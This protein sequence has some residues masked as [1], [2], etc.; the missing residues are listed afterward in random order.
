M[1]TRSTRP[2]V[3]TSLRRWNDE[4]TQDDFNVEEECIERKT[5]TTITTIKRSYPS[6]NIRPSRSLKSLDAKEYPLALTPT[7]PELREF[8]YQSEGGSRISFREGCRATAALKNQKAT[9]S[10]SLIRSDLPATPDASI[11][12]TPD[13]NEPSQ[14]WSSFN[15][16]EDQRAGFI[17]D[18]NIAPADDSSWNEAVSPSYES[19]RDTFNTA[20]ATPPIAESDLEPL[21][22]AGAEVST[23]SS[24]DVSQ[25]RHSSDTTV[26]SN[27]SLPSPRLSPTLA[28]AKLNLERPSSS[29]GE[30]TGVPY[31]KDVIE[32][33]DTMSDEMK[34]FMMYK[35]LQR[36]PRKTL[37]TI[38]NVLNPALR[39]DFLDRLPL[40]L[41]YH[42]L[43]FLD[44]KDL[45]RA[46]QVSKRWRNIIDQN[47][48]GWRDLM[49]K[50]GFSIP[51]GEL[52]RAIVEGWGWQGSD[53]AE[54]CEKDISG[55][56]E[57]NAASRSSNWAGFV[58][59]Q[60]TTSGGFRT[61]KRKRNSA[62]SVDR[63]KRRTLSSRKNPGLRK[64]AATLVDSEMVHRS[65]AP[66]TAASAAALAL[67]NPDIGLPD[68]RELHLFK[69]LYRRY[70]MIKRNWTNREVKPLHIA[71]PAH[72][73]FVITCLQF[74]DDKIL[75][76]SDD[77]F[78]H[79]YD[80]KTGA[81]RRKLEGHEGGVWAL[82][83]E[84][85]VLVSGSTDR[86]VRVWDIEKGLCTQVFYGHTSTVRCLQILMPSPTG[87][88]KHGKEIMMPAVP[89]I[90]TGS[91]DSQLRVWRL[92]EQGEK[93][94]L[95]GPGAN[96]T[97]CPFF[98]K[99]LTGHT[100]SVRAIAA[101]GDTLVS[102]S[103]DHSVRVWRISEGQIVHRLS[104]HENKVYSVVLD[105]DRNRCISGSM[106]NHVRI[107]SLETGACLYTLAGHQ[108][109]V[110]LLDLH[111]GR[112][113]SAAADST[114]RI[115]DPEN[116]ECK[117]T[118]TAHTAAITCFQHDSMKVISGSDRTVKM[119]N[120]KTGECMQDLLTDLS[121]VWQVR[122]DQ[123]RC[124]AAVQRSG[125]TYIEIL[126]FG[127][128]RDGVPSNRRGCRILVDGRSSSLG[129]EEIAGTPG[130]MLSLDEE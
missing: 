92:P 117:H 62:H 104:G 28:A 113:V 40:E 23:I 97:D 106:D 9:A 26:R 6:I 38:A 61:S 86:S 33:F 50:D 112:L 71:F 85:N 73:R 102:G 83:Y 7:P 17:Q 89:L 108:S 107:W 110:G 34:C 63:A 42:I 52:Q 44:C 4:N 30:M 74:D 39:C 94:Y 13:H 53:G 46:A 126:D 77:T 72:P 127:A 29:Y 120:V 95:P 123:R 32:T 69:S 116:G 35:L 18:E 65:E 5:V 19:F 58:A 25:A 90:I 84:G 59:E 78:I 14:S 119:W 129:R 82:Q 36:C 27:A 128:V 91:R 21:N 121:G 79:V 114:L 12:N 48:T 68:L 2:R 87:K 88:K 100:H 93:R 45:C 55:R 41:T 11:L 8:S 81:L 70:Y 124:V 51:P 66:S 118:L 1:G 105:K 99:L 15:G 80:T 96:D 98:L 57:E 103:Y 10:Y 47:E 125:M 109:L 60:T 101:H 75:T 76:G 67:P 24:R 49:D 3:K 20:V 22:P 115:W 16:L 54:S 37:H 122:F 111:D 31:A 56:A 130:A 43:G 64:Q